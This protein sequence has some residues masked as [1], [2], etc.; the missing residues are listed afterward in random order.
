MLGLPSEL[1]SFAL[2]KLLLFCVQPC[3]RR[4]QTYALKVRGLAAL[5]NTP[6][7]QKFLI[8]FVSNS[9]LKDCVVTM[10]ELVEFV[11]IVEEVL[12]HYTSVKT[13]V[14]EAEDE[15]E[16]TFEAAAAKPGMSLIRARIGI[17]SK[18]KVEQE[19]AALKATE[20]Q[21][22]AR[23]ERERRE[24][25]QSDDVSLLAPKETW[26][27]NHHHRFIRFDEKLPLYCCLCRR[28][29]WEVERREHEERES[30]YRTQ[31][32]ALL[33]LKEE[34]LKLV[35]KDPPDDTVS[36]STEDNVVNCTSEEAKAEIVAEAAVSLPGSLD[37]PQTRD[38]EL[39]LA[40]FEVVRSLV[41][42]T[43]RMMS[44]D[45]SDDSESSKRRVHKKSARFL[46]SASPKHKKKKEKRSKKG[47]READAALQQ[48]MTVFENEENA[49]R[50]LHTEEVQMM[51][52]LERSRRSVERP[53]LQVQDSAHNAYIRMLTHIVNPTPFLYRLQF[54][55][56]LA[57]DP[58][59]RLVLQMHDYA[60]NTASDGTCVNYAILQTVPCRN[61]SEGN[62]IFKQIK[63]I[64]EKLRSPFVAQVVS[65]S[66]HTFQFFADSG[67]LVE[68]WP[69]VFVATEYFPAGSWL[70]F[71]Q[72][73]FV[74]KQH[75]NAATA[76]A[77]ME[78]HLLSIFREVAAG[79]SAMHSL[80]I[81][82]LNVNL[83]NIYVSHFE[84]KDAPHVKL[85]GFL[86]SKVAF[87]EEQLKTG[88]MQQ[89]ID[90]SIAPPEV[91]KDHKQVTTKADVWMLGCALYEALLLW[92]RQQLQTHSSSQS[93]ARTEGEKSIVHL[94]CIQE[95]VQEIPISTSTTVRSLLRMLL[96]PNPAQRPHMSQVIDYLSFAG[97]QNLMSYG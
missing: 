60:E 10:D 36:A 2:T 22:R 3:V 52:F 49:R 26:E 87:A 43:E 63:M 55:R 59:Q 33:A 29:K 32:S 50:C 17:V 72:E 93:G 90:Y 56:C 38:A 65:A 86:A 14:K 9:H 44:T 15:I 42:L 74:Q 82:H 58:P 48:A 88:T 41:T 13:A 94:K 16:A 54:L 57:F 78:Q 68:C 23:Q 61:E 11:S 1:S 4:S 30:Q 20:E 25:F 19:I 75:E 92:Q 71:F 47:G 53:L 18:K 21:I 81:L 39:D 80:G 45:P 91:I 76:Y 46:H 62:Q 35:E 95:I 96:Q 8:E 66:K 37:A 40:V 51:L 69:I 67:M 31:W 12:D 79:L 7:I 77:H 73:R 85:S 27:K 70:R 84:S 64:E 6:E 34:E 5:L 97:K 83:E 24:A 89:C 28:R